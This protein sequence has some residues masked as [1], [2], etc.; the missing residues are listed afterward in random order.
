MI[1][2]RY[3]LTSIQFEGEIE[4][5]YCSEGYLVRYENHAALDNLQRAWLLRNIP[6]HINDL[7]QL[8]KKSKTITLTQVKQNVSFD[9]FWRR[10]DHKTVSS[11]KKALT[12]WQRMSEAE[13]IKAYNYIPR[14]LQ[15]LP[16]GISKKYAETYLNSQ[17]WN[18]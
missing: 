3:Y 15:N 1:F 16:T 14:Y 9:D 8:G 10:Y 18:N 17:L 6:I 12:A 13:Q 7:E 11:K 4:F 2:N 5:G